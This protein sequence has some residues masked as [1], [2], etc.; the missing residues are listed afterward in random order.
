MNGIFGRITL[1]TG[2]TDWVFI[3][4]NKV[5]CRLGKGDVQN[6]A[7]RFNN[8]TVHMRNYMNLHGNARN[9][10]NSSPFFE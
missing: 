4:K 1:F 9:L 10:Q 2:Q 3:T 7:D 8:I 5:H 6:K